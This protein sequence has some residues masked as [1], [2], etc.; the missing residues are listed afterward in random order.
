M[1]SEVKSL[2]AETAKAT[3]EINSQI[4]GIQSATEEAVHAIQG[5]GK[6]INEVN[7]IATTIAS[8]V[9]EQSAATQEIARNVEQAAIGTNEVTS[10]ITG[11]TQADDHVAVTARGPDGTETL[12]A[13]Y[14]IGC[15]GANSFVGLTPSLGNTLRQ[16]PLDLGERHVRF[17][18]PLG[19]RCEGH[20]LMKAGS[21][22]VPEVGACRHGEAADREPM[23]RT[24]ER[25]DSR[26]A[27]AQLRRLQCDLHR[28]RSRRAEH[29]PGIVPGSER[30]QPL[31]EFNLERR[32]MHISHTMDEPLGLLH[33]GP[34]NSGMGVTRERDPESPRE[35]DVDV[36]VHVTNVGAARFFPEDGKVL[37]QIG[38]VTGLDRA[39]ALPERP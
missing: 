18:L 34:L 7:E 2:A 6:T 37:G 21:E 5:I 35:V 38:D 13:A 17:L 36:S 23:V 24:L 25:D 29:R 11:V 8:A 20:P 4:S 33:Q 1:A 3:E 12:R 15:D 39:Q 19:E 30:A 9:E 22:R 10:N 14:L 16:Q 31:Q 28:L 32:G 27:R 26:A